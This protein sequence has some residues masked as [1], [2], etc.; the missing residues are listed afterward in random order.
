MINFLKEKFFPDNRVNHYALSWV[1]LIMFFAGLIF[2][3]ALQSISMGLL[4]ANVLINKD[5]K[6]N[7]KFYFND[8]VM[9]V[10]TFF[11]L[12]YLL[13]GFYSDDKKFWLEK[14]N[15]RL[16]FVVIPIGLVAMRGMSHKHFQ[17]ALYIF[18][19]LIVVSSIIVL[20]KYFR[21]YEEINTSYSAGGTMET[22]YS[23]IRFSL[24]VCFCIFSGWFLYRGDFQP[25]FRGEKYF[26]LAATG[27]LVLFLHLLAVR[28][29]LLAFYICALFVTLRSIY[30]GKKWKS[31]IAMIGVQILIPVVA[32]VVF[33]S[34]KS[35][36]DYMQYDIKNYF[37]GADIR[38]LSDA[39]RI[40]S[41]R[42]GIKIGQQNYWFGVGAGDLK[43]EAM[44]F[45]KDM[46]E[47]KDA[48]KLPHNQ[49]IWEFASVGIIGLIIFWFASLFPFFYNRNYKDP[50]FL[51]LHIIIFSSYLTEAT[52]DDSNGNGLYLVFLCL[53]YFQ[54]LKQRT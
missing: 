10:L 33:P 47:M 14:V 9:V 5:A 45:Y 46:P 12:T 50:L 1:F 29:G 41:I 37:N 42:T 54:L 16:A 32:Y 27:F 17:W 34:V 22:P 36:V 30:F 40:Y 26:T 53:I 11:L 25:L 6:E 35:R 3:H 51:C 23:H 2:S 52:A 39:T 15:L 20:A 44:K 21:N 18:L 38:G 49:I 13:S 48:Y 8:R 19:W 4:A 7:L 43:N 24:M 31:G 28:S